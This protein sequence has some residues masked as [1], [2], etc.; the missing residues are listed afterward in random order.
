MRT[1]AVTPN[2]FCLTRATLLAGLAAFALGAQAQTAVPGQEAPPVLSQAEFQNCLSR[3]A[4]TPAFAK[5]SPETLRRY[6]GNLAPDATVL[7]LLN[8]QPEFSLP[9]W[10]YLAM[11]VDEQRVAEGKAGFLRWQNE[12]RQIEQRYGVPADI[13]VGVWGV[14]SNFGQ[15]L[16]GR[17]LVQSLGTLSCFGRRQAYFGGEFASALRILQEGHVAEEQLKGS[18]AGA[19]GQT[20]FMPSTFFR[21]A[22]DFDGDGRRDIVDSVPDALASTAQFLKNAGWRTGQPWGWEVRLPAGFDTSG[23]G[24]KN[25]KPIASWRAAGVTL[26][27]GQ[28]LPDG[29]DTAG[30]MIPAA[31]GPAFLVGRNFDALYSYNASENYGLAI[32]QLAN[33][34]ASAVA[35]RS[36]QVG[37][38]TPW[39]TDDP[40]LSRAQN[41][42]LQIKLLG[43]GHAIGEPDGM[44]GAKTR[45]AIRAEQ[46]R[47][48]MKA[49]GRAGQKLLRALS[50]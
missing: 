20:Q 27:N 26:V 3:L 7:P 36:A 5:I 32:A 46:Q 31:G 28:P 43:R 9:V 4:G 39:P 11:L 33:V 34:V 2:P 48:G 6:T 50:Q 49:D 1:F 13:V 47:L 21:S 8:R 22:V 42:A 19:F 18:W 41:K 44:I 45:D 16:G 17:S 38:V 12:L 30:L 15:N 37:F 25:K 29:I 14:E 35:G 23:A 40:G 24:R 10:D